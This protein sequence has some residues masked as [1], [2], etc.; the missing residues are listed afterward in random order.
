MTSQFCTIRGVSKEELERIRNE[1]FQISN[2]EPFDQDLQR[3]D[4]KGNQF[5]VKIRDVQAGKLHSFYFYFIHQ[6]D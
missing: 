2:I 6:K 3:G 1:T 4:L 5:E